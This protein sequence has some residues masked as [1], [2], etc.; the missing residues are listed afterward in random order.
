MNKRV[1]IGCP[2]RNRA[3]ILP[4]YLECLQNFD[5]PHQNIEYCFII[6]DCSDKTPQILEQFA[7]E[8]SV[9]VRLITANLDSKRSHVRGAY[10]FSHLAVLRNLLLY[11]FLN[12]NCQ[13]LFSI[14]SD[15][16]ASPDTLS[17]LLEHN[18]DIVSVLVCNGHELGDEAIYN[19]LNRTEDGRFVHLREFPRDSI[20]R[21]D[22]T[23]AACLI[24]RRV[25]ESCKVRYSS[26]LGAEDIGFC[27][28]A[29][30]QGIEIYCD[31]RIE[32]THIMNE[33]KE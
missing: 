8:Q 27:Q 4:Q 9:P 5:Y 33:P 7:F 32:C 13:Y 25:I 24:K 29:A 22:C 23:G 20:F 31:G 6:N 14:D 10:K 16:L 26:N 3:W 1:M 11:S 19:I 17:R 2:I 28:A 21:V 18:C 12:S 15:I 30:R